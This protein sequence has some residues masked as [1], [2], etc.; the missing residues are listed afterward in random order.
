VLDLA[1]ALTREL[2]GP[3]PNVVGGGRPGDVRHVVADPSRIRA[4][5]NFAAQVSFREGTAE[6]ATAPMRS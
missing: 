3:A 1:T 4:E 2:G 6:F 5:L